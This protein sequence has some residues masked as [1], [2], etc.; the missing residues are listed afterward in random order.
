MHISPQAAEARP[1]RTRRVRLFA[2][3]LAVPALLLATVAPAATAG[4]TA[5]GA[6]DAAVVQ[7]Q[8]RP[9][10]GTSSTDVAE[11]LISAGYDV[12]GGGAGLLYVHAPASAADALAGRTD[13]TVVAQNTIA[14]DFGQVPP[15]NLDAV[16]PA[17]LDGGGYE[18]YY[19]GYRTTT[20]TKSSGTISR[21]P[22]RSSSGW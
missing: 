18:T 4:P 3:A 20:P 19:G 12:Y 2:A 7:F 6:A 9:A 14:T 17:R 10:I 8:V 16:L 22:T 11:S 21:T 1:A 15:A 13:L 5:N